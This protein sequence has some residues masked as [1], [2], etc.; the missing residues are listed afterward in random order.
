MDKAQ[1]SRRSFLLSGLSFASVVFFAGCGGGE[2][3]GTLAKV[4]EDPADKAK[5]SMDYYKKNYLKKGARKM[6]N[7]RARGPDNATRQQGSSAPPPS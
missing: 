7:R 1:N 4:D 3:E 2:K 6:I 5:D